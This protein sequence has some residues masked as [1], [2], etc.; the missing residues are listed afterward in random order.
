MT[1]AATI[2]KNKNTKNHIKS[3]ENC[4]YSGRSEEVMRILGSP[5]C[6]ISVALLPGILEIS[7]LAY[8]HL[9]INVFGPSNAFTK[10]ATDWQM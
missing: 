10:S 1:S 7:S 6:V 9:E 3:G 5:Y 4:L 8:D 2:N